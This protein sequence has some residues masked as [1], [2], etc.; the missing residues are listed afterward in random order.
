MHKIVLRSIYKVIFMKKICGQSAKLGIAIVIAIGGCPALEAAAAFQTD[1]TSIPMPA[2]TNIRQI[3][4]TV[5]DEE[6]Q[7]AI[8]AIV[9]E[10][11][12]SNGVAAD[13]DGKYTL[14]VHNDATIEVS[15]AG[16]SSQT[17][18]AEEGP[19]INFSLNNET[20]AAEEGHNDGTGKNLSEVVVVGFGAQKKVNLTGSVATIDAKA[21]EDR[22]VSNA[23]QAL[24]GAVP[25]LQIT[26]NS[27]ALDKS[28]N[29]NVRGTGTIGSSSGSPL[30]LIDGMEGDLSTIN[31]QDIATISVLKDAAASSIY[32]SRAPFGV[33]LV[34]T[35]SGQKGTTKVNYNNNFRWATPTRMPHMANSL[36]FIN[37]YDLANRN[38]GKGNFFSD[39]LRRR[40]EKTMSGDMSEYMIPDPND[41]TKWYSDW[42]NGF[43]ANTDWYGV[44]YKDWAFSQ[45]HNLSVTGGTEKID[46]YTS[47]NFMRQEG[48]SRQAEDV[49][50][51]Y[52][53]TAKINAT[54]APWARINLSTRFIRKDY[55]R[56]RGLSGA[57]FDNLTMNFWPIHP[58]RDPNGYIYGLGP[59]VQRIALGGYNRSQNDDI[60]MQGALVLEPIK[61]WATHFEA[62]YR[63]NNT[64][65]REEGLPFYN[66]DVAGNPTGG[67]DRNSYVSKSH[68]RTN[69]VNLNAYTEYAR[70]FGDHNGKI[71][72]GFQ[73]EGLRQET[74]GYTAYGLVSTDY[75]WG[76]LTTNTDYNG[77]SKYPTVKGNFN[78]W[79]T[80]GF[81]G[82]L[83]YD[84]RGTY[85]AE[86]NLRYDGTSRF[87]RNDRWGL[88]PSVSVGYNLAN[89]DY[90]GSLR[91]VV[92][93]LKIRASYGELGNQNTNN[94][95]PMYEQLSFSPQ[96]GSWIQNGSKPNTTIY[97]NTSGVH[98]MISPRLTWE[99][100]QSW[101]IGLDWGLFNGRLNGSLDL[102]SRTTRDMVGPGPE[103]PA[104]LGA[105]NPSANNTDLRTNGFELQISWNDRLANGFGYN[106]G[107]SLSDSRSK[108]TKYLNNP[109]QSLDNYIE[110]EYIGD[111]YGY[112]TIGI[113]QTD[114]EMNAYLDQLDRNYEAFHG[115]APETPRMGMAKLGDKWAAGDIMYADLNGDGEI[116]SGENTLSNHGDYKK[117][118]NSNPRYFVGVNLGADWKGF[119]VSAFFQGVLKRDY[120]Q[121][122]WLFWGG[123]GD[124][125]KSTVLL[126]HLDYWTPDNPD[127]YYPRP[128]FG[129]THGDFHLNKN[130]YVQT[131]YIQ[132]G[133][134][135][136]LKN[137][138]IGYTLPAT[139]TQK[140]AISKLRIYASAENLFVITKMARMFDP[141][142]VDG[143]NTSGK[144][145][146]IGEA[147][148]LS[149]TV[150]FGLSITL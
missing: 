141:E 41:P 96:G 57:L 33:I 63:I 139:L 48:L 93:T 61:G 44:V 55:D 80:A 105:N 30:I 100:I 2:T 94:W 6:G 98:N 123:T 116:N 28:A 4:G 112:Q 71:M 84:F 35:K 136:R 95:Y 128:Y 150:S 87:L 64:E 135:L 65:S 138:Q 91:H 148:P 3:S 125:R 88:F 11:G 120:W 54:L 124:A 17:K 106:I 121:D 134:Y 137:V 77:N 45:E 111:I 50:K 58:F 74:D 76:D 8:G 89:E 18:K 38:A 66:H 119:D 68:V 53:L 104:I 73:T 49:L 20:Q 102:Y 82:R 39:E 85:L 25:G 34:T 126:Q 145:R 13:I 78:R 70:S 29:I 83:N 147:Y 81:F 36:D 149:T 143:G 103:L 67:Y 107:A 133:A 46:Y 47:A 79:V 140:I 113:A 99:R 22:P 101:N 5:L 92:N 16:Y 52:T 115:H 90:W 42:N 31:P 19:V 37:Y 127:A 27:G 1:T 23:V 32:G 10:K 72:A 132:N 69:Y 24:Q 109:T 40:V 15:L 51:R 56:P 122:S 110:G 146:N 62:N 86:V 129:S 7:P 144:N 59:E 60:Y 118:G 131:R 142:T 130:Q 14:S 117:I 21:L 26:N 75:P 97:P 12:T 108:I 43:A 9:K 114:E